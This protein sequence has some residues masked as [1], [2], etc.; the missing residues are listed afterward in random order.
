MDSDLT[1]RYI[2]PLAIIAALWIALQGVWWSSW[3]ATYD[4]CTINISQSNWQAVKSAG[5]APQLLFV[6]AAIALSIA[7][8]SFLA[9]MRAKFHLSTLP[10]ITA[11]LIYGLQLTLIVFAY[12]CLLDACPSELTFKSNPP[13]D[14]RDMTLVLWFILAVKNSVLVMRTAIKVISRAAQ[15]G[16][17]LLQPH[18]SG[19]D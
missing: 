16:S 13:R 3:L 5:L 2:V 7:G 18:T 19:R 15:T 12:D 11:V 14:I 6:A 1:R 4:A 8:F 9:Q 10:A 17:E